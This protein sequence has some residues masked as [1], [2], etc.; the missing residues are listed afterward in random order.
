MRYCISWTKQKLVSVWSDAFKSTQKV[1]NV[2]PPK[3]ISKSPDS[4]VNVTK[5]V[6][7]FPK[8]IVNA[9]IADHEFPAK[10]NESMAI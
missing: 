10:K 6:K 8:S 5:K 3:K 2:G 9:I 4:L 7:D 1:E